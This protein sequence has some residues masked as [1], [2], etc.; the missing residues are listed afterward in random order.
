MNF[1]MQPLDDF[2]TRLG[3][4]YNSGCV[5]NKVATCGCSNNVEGCACPKT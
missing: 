4:L 5:T 1:I 3:S 2:D